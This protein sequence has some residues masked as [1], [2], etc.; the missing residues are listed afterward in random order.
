MGLAMMGKKIGMTQRFNERGRAV[1]VTVIELKPC[2]IVQRK[3]KDKEGYNAIQL[4]IGK[5]KAS[6]TTKP[7]AGHFKKAGLDPMQ[8]L[9]EF[10]LSDKEMEELAEATSVDLSMFES[11]DFVDVTG[12]SKGRGTAGVMKR[13]NMHGQKATHGVHEVFRHGGAIGQCATPGR[14]FKGVKMAGRYGNEKSSTQN[15]AVMAVKPEA[16]L[17]YIRGAVPGPNNGVVVVRKS[18]KKGHKKAIV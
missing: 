12:T 4:G 6:R 18:V 16:N 10:R 7:M 8:N 14:L 2:P 3:T 1:P 15:L 11:G 5:R 13:W 17:I 9:R